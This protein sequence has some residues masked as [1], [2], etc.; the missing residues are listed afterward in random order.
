MVPWIS[1][2]HEDRQRK[3]RNGIPPRRWVLA[4]AHSWLN[5]FRRLLIRWEKRADAYL[6]MRQFA[7]GLMAWRF[8]LSK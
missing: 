4:H 3:R 7:C 2:W 6:A 5:C 8:A 1:A